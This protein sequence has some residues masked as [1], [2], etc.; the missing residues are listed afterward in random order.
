MRKADSKMIVRSRL[1]HAR[2]ALLIFGGA[3]ALAAGTFVTG[4]AS[5]ASAATSLPCDIYAAGGTPCVAAHSTTRALYARLQRP[6]LPGPAL[7]GR[8]HH[9]HRHAQPRAATPTPPRRTR[10]APARPAP[11]RSSTTSP[12]RHND[13]TDRRPA[14]AAGAARQSARTRPRCRSRSAATRSTASTCAAGTGYRNNATTGIATGGQPEGMYMVAERHARQQR[15][16][17]RLRQRRDQQPRHRQRP[18]G[19]HLLR[20]HRAGSPRAPAPARGSW[21]TWRTA[22]SPAATAPTPT[23]HRQQQRVRHRH[24][25]EQRHDHVRD[26]GRQRA[27]RRPD[28]LVQRSAAQRSAATT[29]CTRRAPSS[30][31][32]AATT[33]TAPPARSS[34]AS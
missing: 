13:L 11:S 2:K 24:A 19:R 22:C 15:L 23:N 33:A 26:Q 18:H 1:W 30:W 29:R 21:P 3:M 20:H 14:A 4:A 10:S 16:L 27:V 32:S 31:A 8:R 7:V 5:P 12:P 17:L 28:H 25:Q 9:G 6:A 34:K